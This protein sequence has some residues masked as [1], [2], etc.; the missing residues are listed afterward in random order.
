M[1]AALLGAIISLHALGVGELDSQPCASHA[2]G[3][4]HGD[5]ERR[6]Q[7]NLDGSLASFLLPAPWVAP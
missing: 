6:N 4:D 5:I 1:T 7:S 2:S 3:A